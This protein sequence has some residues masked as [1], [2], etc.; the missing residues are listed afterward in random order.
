MNAKNET[1]QPEPAWGHKLGF[2]DIGTKPPVATSGQ[3]LDRLVILDLISRYAWSYDDRLT[4]SLSNMFAADAVFE[5]N[6]GGGM[7]VGPH[8]GGQTIVD[9]LAS[10]MEG[11]TD[12]RRHSI[13]NHVFAAQTD[14]AATVTAQ[15]LI[16]SAAH[17][18]TSIV[19]SGFYVFDFVKTSGDWRIQRLFAGFDNAF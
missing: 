2:A 19:T 12:Q 10:L 18:A 15:M 1:A 13:A 5:A 17:S 3:L 4:E 16:T 6:I 7:S 14:T 8:T 11:Q 9:W